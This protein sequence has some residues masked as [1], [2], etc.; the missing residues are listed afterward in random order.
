MVMSNKLN[1]V[2]CSDDNYAPHLGVLICSIFENKSGDYLVDI[3][4]IDGGIS[5][6]NKRKIE[7]LKVK[8]KFNLSFIKVKNEDFFGCPVTGYGSQ[9]VYY[10]IMIPELVKDL[11]KVIYLDC[12][13][14][15]QCDLMSLFDM[16][17]KNYFLGASPEKITKA[18]RKQIGLNDYF[19]YFN[20]AVMVLNLDEWRKKGIS[21]KV[22]NF[23]LSNPNKIVAWDQDALNVVLRGS[24][25]AIESRYNFFVS[26]YSNCLLEEKVIHYGGP[27][28]PWHY[29]YVSKN[30]NQ[31][32]YF[33][34]RSLTEWKD[35]K[36][37]P[38][39]YKQ[40]ILRIIKE[41]FPV[42]LI[43]FLGKIKRFILRI[44]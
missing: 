16:D 6:E 18:R 37:H 23:I 28:K 34:Y 40:F 21:Q 31:A 9:A 3:R 44:N 43:L 32:P 2:F 29:H 20:S 35:V 8:Y 36:I 17:L 1:L 38:S 5:E 4:V 27:T 19:E 13:I 10:R 22:F 25:L 14:I 24:W 12:D 33:K 26:E 42:N 7:I 41:L 15:V 11:D 39:N 30:N